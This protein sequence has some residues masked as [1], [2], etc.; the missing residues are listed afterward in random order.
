VPH[1]LL[2]KMFKQMRWSWRIPTRVQLNKFNRKNLEQYAHYV[3]C[4][5]D[6]P[7]DKLKFADEAHV[8]EKQVNKRKVLGVVGNRTWVTDRSLHGKSF[9]MTILT[10]LDPQLPVVFDFRE[11]SNSQ[12]DFVNFVVFC[13]TSGYLTAGDYLVI[14]NAPVHGGEDS[15]DFLLSAMNAHG[16]KLVFLPKYSPELNPAELVFN[17]VKNHLRYHRNSQVPLWVDVIVALAKV[18]VAKMIHFYDKCL[19]LD[20]IIK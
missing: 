20:K 12:W 8:V 11:E 2:S 10:A 6:I 19:S 3:H 18:D 16:V 1:A 7:W 15:F 5:Q 17:I 14:D 4:V 13:L 9:S